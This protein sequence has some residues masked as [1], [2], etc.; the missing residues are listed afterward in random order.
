VWSGPDAT[1]GR[2]VTFRFQRRGYRDATVTQTITGERIEVSSPP[3]ESLYGRKP[4]APAAG[5]GTA[6]APQP[7]P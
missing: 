2:E 3:L 1:L 6:Q 5:N 4:S 7:T